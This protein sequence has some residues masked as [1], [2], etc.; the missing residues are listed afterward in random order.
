MWLYRLADVIILSGD[1]LALSL[2]A[3]GLCQALGKDLIELAVF[4]EG[5]TAFVRHFALSDPDAPCPSCEV[6]ASEFQSFIKSRHGCDPGT[7]RAPG[8][9]PTRTQPMTCG[10]AAQLGVAEA[11]K[12]MLAVDRRQRLWNEELFYSMIPHR[13]VRTPFG[14]RNPAC[15]T[16]HRRWRLIDDDRPPAE[17]TLGALID[18]YEGLPAKKDP[19][20][21]AG[22][23]LQVR[24][25]LP[26]VSFTLCSA[27][28]GRESVLRFGR[29]GMEL[30]RR[31]R[32]GALL[33]ATPLGMRCVLPGDDVE[34]CRD[35]SLEDLGLSAGGAIGVSRG[36]D[37]AYCFVGD[38]Y[39][40]LTAHLKR[41]N[42]T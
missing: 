5:L 13:A 41:E 26:W 30:G 33:T 4:G 29:P 23:L 1:N 10:L 37:W 22:G 3:G 27:C 11:L 40:G 28:G 14:D 38:G 15:R 8:Q 2:W 9:E 31:C 12:A 18:R 32:C 19:A 16:P 39:Q 25:E 34:S 7:M 21:E 6:G 24:G 20:G 35:R 36:D 42:T 17:V